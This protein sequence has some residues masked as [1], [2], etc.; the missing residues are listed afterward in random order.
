M[1]YAARRT[2]WG[3]LQKREKD[4]LQR[5]HG[6]DAIVDFSGAH[7]FLSNNYR[8]AVTVH[9]VVYPT[10]QHVVSGHEDGRR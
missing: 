1:A 2:A 6:Q 3:G 9:G 5:R 8:H 4:E 7:E 10:A